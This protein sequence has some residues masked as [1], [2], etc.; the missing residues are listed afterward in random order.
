[1]QAFISYRRSDSKAI[2]RLIGEDLRA[3]YGSESVFQDVTEIRPGAEF[4]EDIRE[5]LE[6]SDIFLALIGPD[7]V[8]E[9][10]FSGTDYIRLEVETAFKNRLEVLPILV[11][12]GSMP[13]AGD[14]PASIQL[15]TRINAIQVDSGSDFK[16][17]M[18]RVY[19]AI[20]DGEDTRTRLDEQHRIIR[21]A[22]RAAFSLER[23][24]WRFSVD[25]AGDQYVFLLTLKRFLESTRH[26]FDIQMA[27]A[28]DLKRGIES[29]RRGLDDAIREVADKIP[30]ERYWL[31]RRLRNETDNMREVH[32]ALLGLLSRNRDAYFLVPGLHELYEH[33]S[34]WVAKYERFRDDE[35]MC[36]IFVGVEQ[37]LRFPKDVEAYIC[38]AV[39]E[40]DQRL[41]FQ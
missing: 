31:R 7:W 16:L 12:S 25:V 27:L 8:R 4:P 13:P 19:Q 17:H 36:L 37:N 9:G 3:R 18:E 2:A 35:G 1:V 32:G 11:E 10:A 20:E 22:R 21:D 5:A 28:R 40:L 39:D 33:L 14:L 30:V 15:L 41:K 34:L 29:T 23:K 26:L 38:N 24:G 6:R